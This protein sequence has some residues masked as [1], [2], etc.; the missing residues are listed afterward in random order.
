M[1]HDIKKGNLTYKCWDFTNRWQMMTDLLLP[2]DAHI[3]TVGATLDVNILPILDVNRKIMVLEFHFRDESL[4]SHP[5]T[6]LEIANHAALCNWKEGLPPSNR[7]LDRRNVFL[8]SQHWDWTK[9]HIH[10]SWVWFQ[11]KKWHPII[12]TIHQRVAK[13]HFS[14]FSQ[15]SRWTEKKTWT[16][17]GHHGFLGHVPM[18]FH[19]HVGWWNSAWMVFSS[20][21]PAA[22]FM[23]LPRFSHLWWFLE[24]KHV[25]TH[26]FRSHLVQG[27]TKWVDFWWR[28]VRKKTWFLLFLHVLTCFCIQRGS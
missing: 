27:C 22:C 23:A 2:I 6:V 26:Q 12:I 14:R 13:L 21:R 16:T 17:R 4:H 7:K 11:Q 9:N 15:I 20:H 19:G 10:F 18:A 1:E 24:E 5:P 25:E 3:N 8:I 28:S